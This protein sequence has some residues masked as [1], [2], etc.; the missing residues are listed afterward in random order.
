MALDDDD[1]VD[2]IR[3]DTKPMSSSTA[4]MMDDFVY[5]LSFFAVA[6]DDDEPRPVSTSISLV[7]TVDMM[8]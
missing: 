5:C 6:M 7:A 4:A 8:Y 1:A 2:H 3:N